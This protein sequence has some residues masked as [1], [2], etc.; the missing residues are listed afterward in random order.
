MHEAWSA[1]ISSAEGASC[2]LQGWCMLEARRAIYLWSSDAEQEAALRGR[3]SLWELQEDDYEYHEIS[4]FDLS[5]ISFAES[6]V[7]CI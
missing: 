5:E 6:P 3:E 1:A 7:K 2:K 4:G